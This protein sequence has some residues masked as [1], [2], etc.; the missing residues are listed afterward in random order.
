MCSAGVSATTAL[1]SVKVNVDTVKVG[2]KTI[3]AHKFGL[4]EEE[5]EKLVYTE[6][7]AKVVEIV[8][9]SQQWIST[10]NVTQFLVRSAFEAIWSGCRVI[11]TENLGGDSK[12]ASNRGHGLLR[13]R[14]HLGW[15][16]APRRRDQVQRQ[17]RAWKHW[18]EW[19]AQV[20]R[21]ILILLRQFWE[22]VI[23]GSACI[24]TITLNFL[25]YAAFPY[26]KTV[27]VIVFTARL[28]TT[29]TALNAVL[30]EQSLSCLH[31]YL[32]Q[33]TL[34]TKTRTWSVEN[35]P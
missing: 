32:E 19:Q 21:G 20:L 4:Q 29:C 18:R 17:S 26:E 8:R 23:E 27:F 14:R 1:I 15:C 9:V 5:G 25:F 10:M 7:E 22:F 12:A 34:N 31:S 33:K 3:P 35:N 13:G 24:P 11:F 30:K 16:H 28:F 6:E 2:S